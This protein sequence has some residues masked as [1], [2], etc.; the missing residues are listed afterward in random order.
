MYVSNKK[1]PSAITAMQTEK[2]VRSLRKGKSEIPDEIAKNC[3]LYFPPVLPQKQINAEN[4]SGALNLQTGRCVIEASKIDRKQTRS[5]EKYRQ[6]T[7]R[8]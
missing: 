4:M 2:T 6:T 3:S 5:T 8:T 7:T 1:L